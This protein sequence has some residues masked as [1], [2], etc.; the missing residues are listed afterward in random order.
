MSTSQLS[1]LFT[2]KSLGRVAIFYISATLF[3]KHVGEIIVCQGESMEGTIKSGDIVWGER[4]SKKLK[5]LQVGDIVALQA[6]TDATKLLCKRITHKEGDVYEE[7]VPG[8]V[9]SDVDTP[10]LHSAPK[11]LKKDLVTRKLAR[12]HVFVQ[13][14]NRNNSVDSRNFGPISEHLVDVRLVLRIYPFN[15]IG[16][17]SDHWFYDKSTGQFP[18]KDT[19]GEEE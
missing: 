5:N 8:E 11:K 12:N 14:D 9:N 19:S 1:D 16:W 17:L 10:N 18:I 13:G 6:P 15:R 2:L 7:K 4:W 3:T